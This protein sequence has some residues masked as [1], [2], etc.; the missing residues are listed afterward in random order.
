MLTRLIRATSFLF[1]FILL[2]GC[3]SMAPESGSL[4]DLQTSSW[5][6]NKLPGHSFDTDR[7]P[8]LRFNDEGNIEGYSGCNSYTASVS[9]N[10]DDIRITD[11]YG[12]KRLCKDSAMTFEAEF[13]DALTRARMW[14]VEGKILNLKSSSG[15]VIMKFGRLGNPARPI[16]N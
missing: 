1:P 16:T 3:S 7:R 6:L 9:V 12:T 14:N 15:D 4:T 10:T 5:V 11:I 13:L 2:A 8:T